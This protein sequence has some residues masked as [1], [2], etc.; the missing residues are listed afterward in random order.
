MDSVT[1]SCRDCKLEQTLVMSI[2]T[3][4]SRS[5]LYH[6]EVSHIIFCLRAKDE[7]DKFSFMEN[8]TEHVEVFT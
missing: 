1:H 5:V 8:D 2:W 3:N 7:K 6:Q 4:L